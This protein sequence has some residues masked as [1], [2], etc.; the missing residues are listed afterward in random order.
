MAK[1]HEKRGNTSRIWLI[2]INDSS[3][4]T[5]AGLTGLTSSSIGLTCY[6]IRDTDTSETSVSL[7]T[8]S[9]LG[10]YT[11]GGFREVSNT[12]MPGW[13]QFC[14]PNAALSSSGTPHSV[15]F[16]FQGASNMEPLPLEV[17]LQALDFDA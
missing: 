3:S 9:A 7:T 8:M 13:Y 5:G 14:P 11:S 15:V 1:R 6:Y 10:S 2:F 4:S 17:Q 12:T 16:H